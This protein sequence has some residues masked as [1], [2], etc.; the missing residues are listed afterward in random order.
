MP[1]SA[2]KSLIPR[3]L[4]KAIV[5]LFVVLL[6]ACGSSATSEP[7]PAAKAPA[8]KAP[9][10][11]AP[12]AK[13]PAAKAPAAKAPAKAAATAV[14]GR[15]TPLPKVTEAPAGRAKP[16]GTLNHGVAETGI[17]QG[18]PTE[19][20][21]P[22]IQYMSSS[23]GEGLVTIGRDLGPNPMIATC[24]EYAADLANGLVRSGVRSGSRWSDLLLGRSGRP[25]TGRETSRNSAN[26]CEPV[27]N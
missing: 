5:L 10:A 12:A 3:H 22:R 21:S 16:T 15:P 24:R 19:V 4:T 14:P 26:Q 11:K 13:A 7:A 27:S 2:I 25:R 8:A 17:F 6:F 1:H 20:S 23:V 18:H 9:A